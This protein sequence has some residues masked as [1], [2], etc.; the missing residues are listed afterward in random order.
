MPIPFTA[1]GWPYR[2][3]QPRCATDALRDDAAPGARAG[4]P[5]GGAT[6]TQGARPGQSASG[7]HLTR[8]RGR[9]RDRAGLRGPGR[10]HALARV[11]REQFL[12][13][14]DF[15]V[16]DVQLGGDDADED[17]HQEDELARRID[18]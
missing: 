4:R 2:R 17:R 15:L 6:D 3:F 13:L 7:E 8:G 16:N 10:V 12:T 14:G 1:S 9:G 5:Y 11:E 18:V